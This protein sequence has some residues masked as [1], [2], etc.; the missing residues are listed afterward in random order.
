MMFAPQNM[1]VQAIAPENSRPASQVTLPAVNS[2]RP[3]YYQLLNDRIRAIKGFSAF[4][5]DARDMC[6]VP[7]VVLPKKFKVPDLPKY[8]GLSCPHSH[9]T[10]YCRKIAS[11]ID[12]DDLLIHC[13]QDSLSGAFLDWYMSL[14]RTKIRSLRDLSE[15]FLKQYKYNLDMAPTRLQLKNQ[16]Q[17]SNE[18][19]KE[20]AQCWRE[21]ASRVRPTLLDNELVDIF[22]GTLH[23]LYYEKVIG[24]SSTNFADMVTIGAR[25]ENGL[26]SGKITDTTAPQATNKKSYGGFTKKK[27]GETN[28]V[29]ESVHPQYQFP[30]APMPY[31]PYPYVAAAQYQQPPCQYQPQNSNQQPT[32]TQKNQNQQYN[33]DNRG[34]GQGKNNKGVHDD[35]AIC[36]CDQ[37]DCDE[38]RDC[39][40][41]LMDQGLIQFSKSKA[42]EEIA[43]IE[44]ITIV[45]RKK[46]VEAP[47]K[48]IQPI[49]FRVP[50][51]FLYQNT[52]EVP[53]NYETITYLGG[54]EIRILN[55][56]I[57][58]IV[59][60]GGM[61][62]IGHVFAPKY[63]PRVSPSPTVIPPKEKVIPTPQ[64]GATVP[65]TPNM[66]TVSVPTNVID[67]KVAESEMSKGKGPMVE[68]EQVEDHKKSITFEESQEFLKLIKKSDFKI[69]D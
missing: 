43:V 12:N 16:A 38:L 13:F 14:G 46:K 30:V 50:S 19:F 40:Q 45:Y 67:N 18:T 21:M 47:P 3:T 27:E 62:C 32:P 66:T 69:V 64:A 24:S 29:T 60:A 57:V 35:C 6:L 58:N 34:Q 23:G 4:G 5:I 41:K 9:I 49:H 15:D 7:N 44:P 22:M 26:K 17:K 1:P 53:W 56:E 52:K 54:K 31:Y 33:R 48:R 25:V 63:T 2:A 20:Y 37:D 8:K 51:L 55:T 39:V 10:M 68:N 61:T 65:V 59:G 42:A 28:V 36:E 11:Y